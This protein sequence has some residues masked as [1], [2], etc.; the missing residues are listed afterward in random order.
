MDTYYQSV[1]VHKLIYMLHK[2]PDLQYTRLNLG[3]IV[4]TTFSFRHG[5]WFPPTFQCGR[6]YTL[7]RQWV[8]T[9]AVPFFG[10]D[11]LGVNLEFK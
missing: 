9:Y 2:S 1:A 8:V 4:L 5:Q 3:G 10:L 7:P 6:N 11:T